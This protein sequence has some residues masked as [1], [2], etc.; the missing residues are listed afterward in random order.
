MSSGS[1]QASIEEKYKT[2]R[3][4]S[5]RRRQVLLE[6]AALFRYF[7]E[8]DE[9]SVW[10]KEQEVIAGSEDYGT[11]LE[12]VQVLQKKFDDFL[13]DLAASEERISKVNVKAEELTSG[14]HG[15]TKRIQQRCTDI[16]AAWNDVKELAEARREALDG[17]KQVHAFVGDADD[18]IEWIQE[19]EIWVSSQDYGHDLEGVRALIAKHEGFEQDLAAISEQVRRLGII[20]DVIR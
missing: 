15:D 16:N 13:R 5:E 11:D 20:Q 4:D 7:R 18:A 12:H 6:K 2:L 14:G 19:K 9:V 17:A 1:L 8:A 3:E 10:I